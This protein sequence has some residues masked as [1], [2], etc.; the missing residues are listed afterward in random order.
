MIKKVNRM[1]RNLRKRTCFSKIINYVNS[2]FFGF[3]ETA[4]SI[5]VN[6]VLDT[7][8][9]LNPDVICQFND[10]V[11]ESRTSTTNRFYYEMNLSSSSN[12]QT[13]KTINEICLQQF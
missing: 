10:L 12:D 2:Y 5:S 8:A 7:G 6:H 1:E 13:P 9:Q 4:S 11:K 3:T